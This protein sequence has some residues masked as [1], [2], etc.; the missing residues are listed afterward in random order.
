MTDAVTKKMYVLVDGGWSGWSSWSSCSATCGGGSQ[1]KT[2]ACDSPATQHGGSY[3]SGQATST[4]SC[5]GKLVVFLK[6][7]E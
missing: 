4:R 3:C 1:T 2:R 7:L 5:G 6:Y